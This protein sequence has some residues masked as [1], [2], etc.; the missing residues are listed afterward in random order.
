M[1]GLSFPEP[2][3]VSEVMFTTG[4]TGASKGVQLTQRSMAARAISN[5]REYDVRSNDVSITM[6]PLNHIAPI[7]FLDQRMI[8]G[9]TIIFLDSMMKLKLMFDDMD[10]YGVTCIFLPPTGIALLQRLSQN[11]LADY[12]DR[13]DFFS[14]GSAAMTKPQQEYLKRMLPRSRLYCCYASSECGIVSVYRYDG[15]DRDVTC[16]GKPCAAVELRLVDEAFRPVPAGS[17]GLIAVR[18]EMNMLGYYKRPGLTDAVFRD[19]YFVTSDLG[20]LDEEGYLHVLG[21]SDDMINIGGL[22]VLPSE[23]E[24]AALRIPGV[25]E[26]ICFAVP[27]PITGQAAT[28]LIK[29][30]AAFS[31]SVALVKEALSRTM[32]YYKVPKRVE[33]VTEIAKTANGKPDRKHYQT[34][35]A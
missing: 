6:V 9:S 21:R 1:E 35:F 7:M 12:A 25:E 19:G 31:G 13:L 10:K 28:L 3:S 17:V 4:T 11:R 16:Y 5:A 32:D 34:I 8:C 20:R 23:I 33:I 29:T 30:N 15:E 2:D 26:C 18:S 14:T 24:N 27:D 22:K